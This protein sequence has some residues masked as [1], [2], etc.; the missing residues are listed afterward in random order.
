M[1]SFSHQLVTRKLETFRLAVL[2]ILCGVIL[3]MVAEED[4]V[5]TEAQ[6]LPLAGLTV[7][8][9]PGHG[10]YDGGARA[11]DSGVWEKEV[12]LQIALLTE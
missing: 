10:G 11:H 3:C 1:T 9:D 8:L 4:A 5:S 12:T 2:L 6:A 7:A